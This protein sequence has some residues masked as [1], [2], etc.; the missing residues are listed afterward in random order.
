M[1]GKPANWGRLAESCVYEGR[2]GTVVAYWVTHGNAIGDSV[3]IEDVPQVAPRQV[4]IP[5]HMT[6]ETYFSI[7]VRRTV[8][9][10][11]TWGGAALAL[12]CDLF[13]LDPVFQ[14]SNYDDWE[15]LPMPEGLRPGNGGHMS[16]A[17]LII[18][19]DGRWHIVY[20]DY[21]TDHIMVRSTL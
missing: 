11:H 9:M 18:G 16:K 3:I 5:H 13:G 2:S 1:P 12:E 14:W 4:I 10:A 21:Y 15:R 6:M 8:S 17:E 20:H 7:D 19:T